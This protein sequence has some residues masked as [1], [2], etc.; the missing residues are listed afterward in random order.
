MSTK[1]KNAF[2]APAPTVNVEVPL[3]YI[4]LGRL[5]MSPSICAG[6]LPGSNLSPLTFAHSTPPSLATMPAA[7]LTYLH[8]R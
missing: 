1:Q 4:I 3:Q 7:F 5:T 8:C 6:L 2:G